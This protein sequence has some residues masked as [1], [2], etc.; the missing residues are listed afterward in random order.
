MWKYTMLETLWQSHVKMHSG[1]KLPLI[2]TLCRTDLDNAAVCETR[3]ALWSILTLYI[4]QKE[5][6]LNWKCAPGIKHPWFMLYAMRNRILQ[7]TLC[8]ESATIGLAALHQAASHRGH[9]RLHWGGRRGGGRTVW[10]L[11]SLTT[12]TALTLYKVY[13]LKFTLCKVSAR[14]GL[15]APSCFPRLELTLSPSPWGGRRRGE[16]LKTCV[17]GRKVLPP[18]HLRMHSGE[19]SNKKLTLLPSLG[20]EGILLDS[21]LHWG[22]L[23]TVWR[24]EGFTFTLV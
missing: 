5:S 16:G 8:K 17:W 7:I 18:H 15:A 20:R 10:G 22:G 1:E 24:V 11:L 9:S 3:S 19:R 6:F 2:A 14:F 12:C 4:Y 13:T 23:K 21:C